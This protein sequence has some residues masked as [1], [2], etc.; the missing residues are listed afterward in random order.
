MGPSPQLMWYAPPHVGSRNVTH[1]LAACGCCIL[2]VLNWFYLGFQWFSMAFNG[3]IGKKCKVENF[4]DMNGSQSPTNVV[5]T[6]T[7]GVKEHDPPACGVRPNDNSRPWWSIRK[8]GLAFCC[9]LLLLVACCFLLLLV[10]C[11]LLLASPARRRQVSNLKK[12]HATCWWVML[13]D[14]TC[15]GAYHITWGPGP[16]HI[17]KIFDFAVFAYKCIESHW[18]PLKTQIISIKKM[19]FSI[20]RMFF[21]LYFD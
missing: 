5:C 18:K 2:M 17:W 19:K 8:K 9:C 10:A 13:L 20:K 11:S 7:C 16:I 15:G 3:F 21:N 12:P 14:P 4:P 6:P 1:Q